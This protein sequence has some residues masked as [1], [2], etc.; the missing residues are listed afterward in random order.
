MVAHNRFRAMP[1]TTIVPGMPSTTIV[2]GMPSTTIV[3]GMPS[4]TIVP[5]MP[6]TVVVPGML[7]AGIHTSDAVDSGQS[8]PE[9]RASAPE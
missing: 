2:P 1:S 7:L 8:V 9:I 5:G 6:S 3:P 4:T